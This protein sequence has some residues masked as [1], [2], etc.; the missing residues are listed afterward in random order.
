MVLIVIDMWLRRARTPAIKLVLVPG[1]ARRRPQL[2]YVSQSIRA[3]FSQVCTHPRYQED[4]P[5][6]MVSISADQLATSQGGEC[7]TADC[8]V[9]FCIGG[10]QF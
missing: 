9:L 1:L 8:V 7:P 6:L 4:K 3:V 2:T 10:Q 5:F